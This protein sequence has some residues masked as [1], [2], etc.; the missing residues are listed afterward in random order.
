[1]SR[2]HKKCNH[3]I[4]VISNNTAV[5]KKCC[6]AAYHL[7]ML[8]SNNICNATLLGSQYCLVT[9]MVSCNTQRGSYIVEAKKA[10]DFCFPYFKRENSFLM[11]PYRLYQCS[12]SDSIPWTKYSNIQ[13]VMT[14]TYQGCRQVCKSEGAR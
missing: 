12:D 1:M 6:W 14:S 9:L 4:M 8:P 7:I 10:S 13:R 2:Y 3:W 11:T 5:C